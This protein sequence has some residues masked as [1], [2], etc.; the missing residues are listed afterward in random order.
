MVPALTN[1]TTPMKRSLAIALFGFACATTQAS[2]PPRASSESWAPDSGIVWQLS[3]DGD[4]LAAV[5]ADRDPALVRTAP[6]GSIVRLGPM[7][8]ASTAMPWCR[9]ARGVLAVGAL[10]ADCARDQLLNTA[11]AAP[12]PTQHSARV[13]LGTPRWQAGASYQADWVSPLVA[14]LPSQALLSAPSSFS[15]SLPGVN[16]ESASR[17]FG[18]GGSWQIAPTT[19]LNMGAS[20]LESEWRPVRGGRVDIESVALQF[21]IAHGSFS[22]GVVGRVL[23][24]TPLAGGPASD[25]WTGLDIGVA[26]RAPWRGEFSFGARNLIGTGGDAGNA[27]PVIDQITARTPYVRYTQDL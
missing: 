5:P 21:G 27:Q 16:I 2:D 3:S 6:V 17:Q 9:D 14:M 15:G 24:P 12:V 4:W 26:W 18:I 22:G 8:P 25:V 11:V 20:V 23:R 7:S 1:Q 10:A 13:G 19:R